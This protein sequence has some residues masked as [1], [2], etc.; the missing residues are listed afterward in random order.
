MITP[1]TRGC[2]QDAGRYIQRLHG[3]PDCEANI[4]WDERGFLAIPVKGG[5]GGRQLPL[6]ILPEE[7]TWERIEGGSR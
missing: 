4:I 2:P 3:A 1:K 7:T 5:N 6:Y